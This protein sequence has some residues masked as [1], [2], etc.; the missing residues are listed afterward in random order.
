MRKSDLNELLAVLD[1][2]ERKRLRDYLLSPYFLDQ[3][4]VEP[5]VRLLDLLL[6][7]TKDTL[8]E[9]EEYAIVYP[10]DE[11]IV[12]NKLE[13]LKSE[14]LQ[15]VRSFFVVEKS[16]SKYQGELK[17]IPLAEAMLE[18]NLPNQYKRSRKALE[19]W[20]NDESREGW[21][22]KDYTHFLF[23]H[24]LNST[25]GTWHANDE[26]QDTYHSQAKMMNI[27]FGYARLYHSLI[28]QSFLSYTGKSDTAEIEEIA[29]I[30]DWSGLADFYETTQ[31]KL[32]K[33]LHELQSDAS[34]ES[35]I[36]QKV[37]DLITIFEAAIDIL[38]AD[39]FRNLSGALV[40]VLV[41]IRGTTNDSLT[42][43]FRVQKLRIHFT[44]GERGKGV[45]HENEFSGT[46]QT[47]MALNE[48]SWIKEFIRMAKGKING[49]SDPEEVLTYA[50]ATVDY[51]EKRYQ[52]AFDLIISHNYSMVSLRC[53]AKILEVQILYDMQSDLLDGRVEA[54]KVYFHREKAMPA[55]FNEPCNF[56]INFVKRLIRPG[57]TLDVKQ[58]ER[59]RLDIENE[60]NTARRPW[61][62]RVT[63]EAIEK[64]KR[65][66]VV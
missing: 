42:R 48:I 45:I 59:I 8:S 22:V 17:H 43:N 7:P 33:G 29:A 44:L 65:G 46:I 14:L 54:V 11:K 30:L 28:Y 27:Y 50:Y 26:L 21:R 41:K 35:A 24:E 9:K 47:A 23:I 5:Q 36:L 55:S 37:D 12:E 4:T 38:D 3:K 56:F 58:L 62:E 6:Q 10:N 39:L 60:P 66:I 19:G 34:S 40:N 57:N 53:N 63:A 16:I 49:E 2:A 51:L 15:Q 31:G 61:L 32:I 20:T 18:K 13:K 64:A 1:T 25:Y 52:D